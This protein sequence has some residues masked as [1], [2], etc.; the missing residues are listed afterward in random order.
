MANVLDVVLETMKA[1]SPATTK[2]VVETTKT[3]AE[4]KT[5][6]AE[7]KVAQA[8][9]EAEAGPSVPT[10]ME[11]ADPKEKTTERIASEGIETPS[12]EASNKSIEYII[13]HA[14]RKELSQE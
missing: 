8:Q 14:S 10:K 7:T 9:T 4:A 5:G 2:K 1:L 3:Q 6:Q 13:L 11:L 12:P